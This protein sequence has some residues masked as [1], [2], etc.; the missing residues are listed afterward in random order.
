MRDDKD[1]SVSWSRNGEFKKYPSC[2]EIVKYENA[3]FSSF[4]TALRLRARRF[5][6]TILLYTTYIH[7]V[8]GALAVRKQ[9]NAMGLVNQVTSASLNT[10]FQF[11]IKT[12][13]SK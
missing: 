10:H 11:S 3:S 1:A 8:I 9:R 4:L 13:L 7:D 12:L 5:R 6:A 2:R